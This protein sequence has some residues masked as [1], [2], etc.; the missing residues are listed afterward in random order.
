MQ[1]MYISGYNH[2]LFCKGAL[3]WLIDHISA[4]LFL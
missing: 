1:H 3:A 4:T 2:R